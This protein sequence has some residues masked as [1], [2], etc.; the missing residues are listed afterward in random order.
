[1]ATIPGALQTIENCLRGLYRLTSEG[2][3]KEAHEAIVEMYIA[4]NKLRRSYGYSEQDIPRLETTTERM[5]NRML[6]EEALRA[7]RARIRATTELTRREEEAQKKLDETKK[8]LE[9]MDKETDATELVEW[10]GEGLP[11]G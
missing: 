1:M 2:Q 10:K 8:R 6:A 11:G 3:S 7:E 5:R 9:E 4:S